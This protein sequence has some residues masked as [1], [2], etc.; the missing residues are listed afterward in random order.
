MRQGREGL[1]SK[2][3]L[4][5]LSRLRRR[6]SRFR[7]Y[8]HDLIRELPLF[9]RKHW[10]VGVPTQTSA[11]VL[12]DPRLL[13][14]DLIRKSMQVANLIEQRLK[15]FVG[16]RHDLP[17]VRPPSD[18]SVARQRRE[19]KRP[20]AEGGSTTVDALEHVEGQRHGTPPLES[21]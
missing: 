14:R 17:R 13:A 9:G 5:K 18:E 2:E 8:L 12:V 19:R 10:R 6:Q 21:P 16:N 20:R 11:N 3:R 4:L 7:E 1:A 15:L